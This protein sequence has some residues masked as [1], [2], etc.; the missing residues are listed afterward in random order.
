MSEFKSCTEACKS[1]ET[2]CPNTDCKNWIDYEEDLN[3]TFI[4]IENFKDNNQV[5]TL[6]DISKRIGCSFVRVKQIEKEALD[7]L[8]ASNVINIDDFI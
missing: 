7:K 5:F 1:L 6:R 4:A 8:N 3:C 2:S